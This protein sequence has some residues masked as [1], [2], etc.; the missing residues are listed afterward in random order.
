VQV[1]LG[2]MLCSI[3]FT[4]LFTL[5]SALWYFTIV[6]IGNRLVQGAGT[7]LPQPTMTP[8]FTLMNVPFA[9]PAA[10]KPKGGLLWL[11]YALV[12]TPPRN[13]EQP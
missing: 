11:R 12:G 2:A 6:W 4:V 7:C 5:G 3:V 10:T 9:S 13:S 8:L 1:F